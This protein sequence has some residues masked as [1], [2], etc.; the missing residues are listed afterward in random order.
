MQSELLDSQLRW[1][2]Q[3]NQHIISLSDKAYP[4]LLRQITDPPPVLYVKGH[5]P[6]L[7]ECQIAMVGTRRMSQY[8]KRN[9]YQFAQGLAELGIIITS[10]LAIGIDSQCH[11]GALMTGQTIAVLGCGLNQVH[12]SANRALAEQIAENGAL[13]SEF[14]LDYPASKFTFPRRN[15]IISGMSIATI[16]VEAALRSG[17]LITA[18]LALEQNR[19]VLAMPGS[20][21]SPQSKGCHHLIRDG[22]ALVES[23]AD[24]LLE[25]K[26]RLTEATKVAVTDLQFLKER[27]NSATRNVPAEYS[28]VLQHLGSDSLSFDHL[29]EQTRLT[30]EQL[31]SMLL[32]MELEGYACQVPGGYIRNN[33]KS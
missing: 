24:I 10:G 23:I 7:N 18:R 28:L 25:L 14:P 8:G 11:K 13:V 3:P 9:A 19:Q 33:E 29:I 30:P 32:M 22:A 6:L 26:P 15:R 16:I 27:D 17:S 5:L 4:E 21:H 2:E 31:S 20:I 1:V 12:L